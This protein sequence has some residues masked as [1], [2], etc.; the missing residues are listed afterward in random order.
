MGGGLSGAAIGGTAEVMANIEEGVYEQVGTINGNPLLV[1]ASRAAL[2]EVLTPAAY[3]HIE[4]LRARMVDGCTRVI[5]QHGLEAY[6]MTLG[7]KGCIT[8]SPTRVRNYRQFL[9]IDDRFSHAHWLFQLL[10]GVFLPPWGKAEQ[11]MLSVQHTTGDADR[12]VSNFERF[13]GALRS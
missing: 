8:F 10:G 13:A 12:F 2:T 1:A 5:E 6:V 7:A 11:W 4:S 3:D 9:E